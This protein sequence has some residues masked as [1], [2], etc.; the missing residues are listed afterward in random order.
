MRLQDIQVGSVVN[1]YK[2]YE[3]ASTVWLQCDAVT[4][5]HSPGTATVPK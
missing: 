4:M 5:D 1:T 2:V 3:H